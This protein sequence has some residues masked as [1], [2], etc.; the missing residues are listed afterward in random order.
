M[1]IS[2]VK[3]DDGG[4]SDVVDAP[5]GQSASEF[6]KVHMPNADAS[7]YMIRVNRAQVEGSRRLADG[8]RVSITPVKIAGAR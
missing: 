2:L 3:N 8:D 1:K 6:F 7:R 5:E 4:F